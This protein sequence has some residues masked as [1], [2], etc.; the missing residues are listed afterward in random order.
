VIPAGSTFVIA[1]FTA[2]TNPDDG[3]KITA[4]TPGFKSVEASLAT[5]G[6]DLTV[7]IVN[8][9]PRNA[10]FGDFIPVAV[11]VFTTGIIPV[12]NATVSV[13][14]DHADESIIMTD[15]N[16]HA[17]GLFKAILPGL[18]TIIVTVSKPG[19]KVAT[20]NARITLDQ[21]VDLTISAKT[22][23]GKDITAQIKVKGPTSLRSDTAK[24]GLPIT[25]KDG[26]WGTY[27]LTPQVDIKSASAIYK[28]VNWSDG[29]TDNPKSVTIIED[30]KI[31]AYY[32][33]QYM[34]QVSSDQGTTSGGGFYAEGAK[35][36]ITIAPTSVNGFLIDKTFGG[37]SGDIQASSATTNVIM[38]SP[39]TVKAVW[40]DGYL[41]I[42]LI[43]GAAG[44]GGFGF[45]WKIIK[46]KRELEAKSRAPDLDWYKS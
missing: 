44:G 28:F 19:Y 45:Y 43:A 23:K 33:A 24:P 29:T 31:T 14:G 17:E 12:K 4:S 39:K 37:W 8:E 13:S 6:Q 27:I 18:N 10:D 2:S 46:P 36:T 34:L 30:A 1:T 5:T 40:N 41:K 25:L 38:N 9:V 15:E 42:F 7:T 20:E 16:G 35:A 21:V 32:S 11:D 3:F 26:K 22:L